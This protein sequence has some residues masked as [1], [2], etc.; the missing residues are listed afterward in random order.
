[1]NRKMGI[2]AKLSVSAAAA[3]AIALTEPVAGFAGEPANGQ[4]EISEDAALAATERGDAGER[5][6]GQT[7]EEIKAGDASQAVE[8]AASQQKEPE[9]QQG[10]EAAEGGSGSEDAAREDVGVE[11]GGTDG[12]QRHPT[13]GE[14]EEKADGATAGDSTGGS[15]ADSED[16]A[17]GTGETD[18]EEDSE[19]DVESGEQQNAADLAGSVSLLAS[20]QSMGTASYL[21]M[22]GTASGSFSE[23]G[24]GG[25]WRFTMP[26][27]G[28]IDFDG[29]AA[30]NIRFTLYD[31][32]GE[33]LDYWI[34]WNDSVTGRA[35]VD[36]SRY[37]TSG[38]YYVYVDRY[39]TS[40]TG[41]FSFKLSYESAN[42]S[43][44]AGHGSITSYNTISAGKSYNGLFALNDEKTFYRLSLGSA[45]RLAL[46]GACYVSSCTVYVYDA[47]G[48]ERWSATYW[49]DSVTGRADFSENLDLTAGTYYIAF[50]NRGNYG[51]FNFST[52]FTSA[53]ESFPE[54][55]NGT[56]NVPETANKAQGGKTYKGQVA[57]NDDKDFYKFEATGSGTVTVQGTSYATVSVHAYNEQMEEV[58]DRTFW[59][60]SGTG[61]V[62]F[63]VTFDVAKG[64]FWVCVG[65]HS[66]TGN[67]SFSVSGPVGTSSTPSS[68][69]PAPSG[70]KLQAVEKVGAKVSWGRV[71]GAD[72]Y[73]VMR[74][75]AGTGKYVKVG[76]VNSGAATSF[77]DRSASSGTLYDYS[78]IAFTKSGSTYTRGEWAAH[79]TVR[80]APA[81]PKITSVSSSASGVR[82]TWT[83]CS[84]ASGYVIMRAPAGS[85]SYV[86]V[87]SVNSGS[88]VSFTDATAAAGKTYNYSVIGFVKNGSTYT[89]GEWAAHKA[90]TAF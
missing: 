4:S 81:A 13:G 47:S 1:M 37:V 24:V 2:A 90:V 27:S 25:W 60:D 48:N 75:V 54:G 84:G 33:E 38:T 82:L 18:G 40:S 6:Q 23:D 49:R 56:D 50:T 87:G 62:N 67:Y 19:G 5:G 83:K 8:E 64:A 3:V 57:L 46:R 28:R 16:P 88:A 39:A 72:G 21:S 58:V 42:A 89:R 30:G 59:V 68:K 74:A 80:T 66:G 20:N 43:F 61:R 79:K 29:S 17:G 41:D 78:V 34:C 22:G 71:S 70:L 15:Q 51:K 63:K 11:V 77:T 53:G 85:S 76:T 32:S 35:L 9:G 55:Q 26:A 10:S 73:V 31:A 12:A 45:G 86:K 14:G 7:S 65:K 69:L 52:S 36:E 44:S